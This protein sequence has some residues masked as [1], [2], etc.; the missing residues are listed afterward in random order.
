M[1]DLS[2]ELEAENLTQKDIMTFLLHST[3]HTAT[4]E[5]LQAV[6]TELKNEIQEVR[7][8]LKKEIQEVRTDMQVLKTELKTEIQEVR[9]DMQV[10]KTEL[11]TEISKIDAKFDRMQ[12]LIISTIVVVLLKEQI[13]SV[14]TMLVK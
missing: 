1:I 9:T 5:E 7:T 4:R 14:F 6:K 11:K 8:E 12:W 10:L 2:Q 3:Q 13:I